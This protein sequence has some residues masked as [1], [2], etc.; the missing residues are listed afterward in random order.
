MHGCQRGYERIKRA[1]TVWS[2]LQRLVVSASHCGSTLSLCL[3]IADTFGDYRIALNPIMLHV[4]LCTSM[5]AWIWWVQN[6]DLVH[7]KD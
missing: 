4:V 2:E 5:H 7:L 6:M 3:T 1:E